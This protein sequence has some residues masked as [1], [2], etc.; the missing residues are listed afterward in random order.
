MAFETL[1]PL[2]ISDDPSS[3]EYGYSSGRGGCVG[4]KHG[5]GFLEYSLEPLSELL[6]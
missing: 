5:K 3:D 6:T 4:L 1:F 2:G